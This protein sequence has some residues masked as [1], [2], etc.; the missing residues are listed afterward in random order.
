MK[1]LNSNSA[2]RPIPPYLSRGTG[3][4]EAFADAVRFMNR[5]E[6]NSTGYGYCLGCR[7]YHTWLAGKHLGCAPAP[8]KE[9]LN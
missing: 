9:H 6:L 2:A 5:H 7:G 4:V 3:Q 8:R 1:R